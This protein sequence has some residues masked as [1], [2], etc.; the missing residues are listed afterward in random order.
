MNVDCYII[1]H[2]TLK[3][4]FSNHIDNMPEQLDFIQV[5]NFHQ[6]SHC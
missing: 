2:M 5:I 1:P 4:F 6:Q 3:P